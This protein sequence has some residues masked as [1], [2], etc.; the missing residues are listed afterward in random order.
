[1]SEAGGGIHAD[2]INL[3]EPPKVGCEGFLDLN[4][5]TTSEI[6]RQSEEMKENHNLMTRRI[7]CCP[8]VVHQSIPRFVA[9]EAAKARGD[10]GNSDTTCPTM[11]LGDGV[12]I[13]FDNPGNTSKGYYD[14]V[15]NICRVQDLS[16]GE[17]YLTN[18]IS[19]GL[20][21]RNILR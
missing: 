14:K 6:A 21:S 7:S 16:R 13:A 15:D 17:L 8:R 10:T 5:A 11:T 4:Y 1:M 3:G 19:F 12:P 20:P 18:Y 2:L 9:N